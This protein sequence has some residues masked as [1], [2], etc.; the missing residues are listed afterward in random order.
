MESSKDFLKCRLDNFSKSKYLQ[1]FI[2]S[3]FGK[4][5]FTNSFDVSEVLGFTVHTELPTKDNPVK[6]TGKFQNMTISR[7][8]KTCCLEYSLFRA[9][10]MISK[11]VKLQY[12]VAGTEFRANFNVMQKIHF[13]LHWFPPNIF[14]HNSSKF[15]AKLQ[16]TAKK[17]VFI[18]L[19]LTKYKLTWVL[20]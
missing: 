19:S 15:S 16:N 20:I 17:K 18:K 6:M 2:F 12:T 9:Y 3:R 4:R 11:R 5:H 7:L 8:N 10:L 14:A 1:Y 13:S